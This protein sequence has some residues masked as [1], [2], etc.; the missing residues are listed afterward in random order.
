MP[1]SPIQPEKVSTAVCR[2]IEMLILQGVLRPEER[3]P[4][5]RDLATQLEVSR[6]TV[7][8]A[9][10]DLESRGLIT[11]RPGGGAF[12]AAILGNAF[13]PPLIELFA[14]QEVA[15][16]DYIEFRRDLEAVAAARAAERATETD[17]ASIRS[18]FERMVNAHQRRNPAEESSIDADFHMAIV[19][20]AHNVVML[21]MARSLYELLRR[22]VFY[23]R[24]VTYGEQESRDRLLEQ[25]RAIHDAVIAADPDA[26]RSAV[27]AHMDFVKAHLSTVS[28]LRSREEIARLRME[29]ENRLIRAEPRRR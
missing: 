24:N 4:A 27:E 14:T 2:Q 15:L 6:P 17:R 16:F 28:Q 11:V 5:E 21:H 29:Q 20:A 10:A 26:A 1:F 9:L 23:N 3:L 13:A 7:R 19:E 8:E 22:G 18:I 12:V 25:H